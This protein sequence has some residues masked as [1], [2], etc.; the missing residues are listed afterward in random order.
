MKYIKLTNNAK[1]QPV[2]GIIIKKDDIEIIRDYETSCSITVKTSN[3]TT[4]YVVSETLDEIYAMLEGEEI[5]T[6]V[7][8]IGKPLYD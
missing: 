1:N 3:G 5:P 6:R 4:T 7:D 2:K 8:K